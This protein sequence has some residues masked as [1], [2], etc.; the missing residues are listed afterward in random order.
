VVADSRTLL[1][2]ATA[3]KQLANADAL[4]FEYYLSITEQPATATALTPIAGVASTSG[5]LV[6]G[7]VNLFTVPMG[8]G[9]NSATLDIPATQTT[10]SVVVVN[11][12]GNT[13]TTKAVSD[14]TNAPATTPPM[15]GFLAGD[16]TTVVVDHVTSFAIQPVDFE[17]EVTI[18]N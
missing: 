9:T 15:V 4:D 1:T 17:L 16:V 18:G 13:R 6:A 5:T 7:A 10:A 8:T 11:A 2:G 3:G 14:E 12:R